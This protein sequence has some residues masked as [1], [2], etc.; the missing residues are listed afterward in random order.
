MSTTEAVHGPAVVVA[1]WMDFVEGDRERALAA[2]VEVAR[3]SRAEPGCVDYVFTADPELPG[4]V[5]VF[6]HWVDQA[7]LT[8]H[9][10]L[11][12]VL[13]LREALAGFTR[14]G[15]SMSHHTLR[16]SRPMGS[17]TAPDPSPTA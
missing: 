17:T 6:E 14:T 9:L 15:R 10:T 13:S 11:P 4:R 8:E 16:E 3:I 2:F 7:S 12:H 1:G 5:R